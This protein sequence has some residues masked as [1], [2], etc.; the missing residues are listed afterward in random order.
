MAISRD[1]QEEREAGQG[2]D[3]AQVE[4]GDLYGWPDFQSDNWKVGRRHEKK[5]TLLGAASS[6]RVLLFGLGFGRWN[7]WTWIA[8]LF[9]QFLFDLHTLNSTLAG[10]NSFEGILGYFPVFGEGVLEP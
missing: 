10:V 7:S 8:I 2:G 3:K 4:A 6:Y 9:I 5:A 1:V